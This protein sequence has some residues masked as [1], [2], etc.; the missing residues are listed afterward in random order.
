MTEPQGSVNIA[1]LSQICYN[2][3][4]S[5]TQQDVCVDV[6]NRKTLTSNR[7]N[8]ER[9]NSERMVEERELCRGTNRN[10]VP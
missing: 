10:D 2:G 5:G 9:K 1:G 8:D 6:T 3:G 4:K 7:R